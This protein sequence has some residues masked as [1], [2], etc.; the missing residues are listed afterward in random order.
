MSEGTQRNQPQQTMPRV[1]ATEHTMAGQRWPYA[2]AFASAI[3]DASAIA[4]I[5]LPLRHYAIRALLPD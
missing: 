1:P 2:S 4:A 5:E 3:A